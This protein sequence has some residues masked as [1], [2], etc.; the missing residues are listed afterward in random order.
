MS[1]RTKFIQFAFDINESLFFY[2]K[3]KRFY[4]QHLK[5][6]SLVIVDVGT[7]K[8]QSIDFFLEL[9]PS[10]TIFGFEPNKE[11]YTKLLSKYKANSNISIANV[12]VSSLCGELTFQENVMDETSTFEEINFD[13]DYLKKKAK[14]LGVSVENIVAKKYKV[15]VI[16]LASF[17]KNH[18]NMQIDVLKIDVEGH[19]LACLLGLFE[20]NSS[21]YSIKYIQLES[22]NDD[23]YFNDDNEKKIETLLSSNGYFLTS[24]IKHGFGDLYELI[25]EYKSSNS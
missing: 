21:S 7:N 25:Y 19:E 14:I 22:H 24:R 6:N 2:N 15:E 9:D 11:L 4:A 3:L 8:G 13:S 17:L 23:M 16:T 1:I 12:G 18:P 5:K 10:A 20:N